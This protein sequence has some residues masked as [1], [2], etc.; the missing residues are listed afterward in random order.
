[1]LTEGTRQIACTLSE[2]ALLFDSAGQSLLRST[3]RSAAGRPAQAIVVRLLRHDDPFVSICFKTSMGQM[4][5]ADVLA[6]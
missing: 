5:Q 2:D 6:G 4:L 1:M 3:Y